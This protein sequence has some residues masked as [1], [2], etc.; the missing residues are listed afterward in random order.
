MRYRARIR[1]NGLAAMIAWNGLQSGFTRTAAYFTGLPSRNS[2]AV[3]TKLIM[4]TGVGVIQPQYYG[5]YDSKGTLTPDSCVNTIFDV[6][7]LSR[8]KF[9]VDL[10]R[11]FTFQIGAGIDVLIGRCAGSCFVLNAIIRGLRPRIAIL[12]S[13]ICEFG[14][15]RHDAGI[16]GDFDSYVEYIANAFPLTHRMNP[17][18]WR[19]FF[20]YAKEFHPPPSQSPHSDVITQVIAV[21]GEHDPVMD[22]EKNEAFTRD[23]ISKYSHAMSLREFIVVPDADHSEESLLCPDTMQV[24]EYYINQQ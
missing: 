16:K 21:A 7:A 18:V 17:D 3:T 24:L 15:K 19:H 5:T 23:F 6:D 13:P 22:V 2:I 4:E 14:I 12:I 9:L 11:G 8:K 10:H 1:N 20:L